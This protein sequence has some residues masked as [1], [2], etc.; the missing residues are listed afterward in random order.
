MLLKKY[1]KPFE[2][3]L[4]M[5]NLDNVK[6]VTAFTESEQKR[7]TIIL[8]DKLYGMIVDKLENI[9]FKEIEQSQGDVTKFKY[10]NRTRECIAVLKSIAEQSGTG[11]D[12]VKDIETALDN[13]YANRMLFVKAFKTNVSVIKY[14]Y[15]TIY[16]AIIADIGFMTT[17]C[18]EFVKNP[19]HTVEIEISN[20]MKYKTRFYLIHKNLKNFNE[21]VSKGELEKMAAPLLKIRSKN[22]M[23][24]PTLGFLFLIP[25]SSLIFLGISCISLITC[26]IPIMRELAY[27]FFSLRMS[28]S[29]YCSLQS[30]LLEAN[31][32]KIKQKTT[33]DKKENIEI[34]RRQESIAHFFSKIANFFAIKYIPTENKLE[35]ELPKAKFTKLDS[36]ELD[37]ID[38]KISKSNDN[39]IDINDEPVSLF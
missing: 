9:D 1:Q 4:D 16:M 8:A 34:S 13:L 36:K 12:D 33:G 26:F 24:V 31:A 29:N 27:V 38:S 17:V 19:D 6:M 35:T 14:L 10:Y 32:L 37:L 11:V 25:G 21:S 20:L 2:E 15:N 28:I 23:G 3:A 39:Q 18:V 22:I 7:A 5:K 30:K